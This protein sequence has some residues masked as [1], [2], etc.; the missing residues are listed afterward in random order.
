M[1]NYGNL[2]NQGGKV[3]KCVNNLRYFQYFTAKE[4]NY[5]KN[6]LLPSYEA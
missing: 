3:K 4:T 2:F 5:G 1:G 6:V